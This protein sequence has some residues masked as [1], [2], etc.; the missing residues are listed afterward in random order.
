M[1]LTPYLYVPFVAWLVAQAIKVL[2]EVFKGE[3]DFRYLY[4]S[5]GM[6][7]AHS[8][9]VCALA[10]YTFYHEGIGSPLFGVTAVIAAIVMYDSFGVRRSAGEQARTLNKLI[11]D[12]SHSGS[13]RKPD[14]YNRL[15]EILGHQPLEVIVGALLGGLIATLFSL[16][17]ISP[18]IEWLTKPL[19]GAEI[20]LAYAVGGLILSAPI[21][22]RLALSKKIKADKNLRYIFKFILTGSITAGI[23][24]AFAGFVAQEAIN[25]YSQRWVSVSILTIW[26]AFMLVVFWRWMNM[27]RV[28]R[29][30]E[31]TG[32]I[33]RD[34]WL[35]KAGKKN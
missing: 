26:V 11:S 24:L 28:S 18:I 29:F 2:I 13:L 9:V 5:G 1:E 4:A 20:T 30:G 12:M 22:I 21:I 19:T 17:Q 35:K 6:P 3:A 23:V 34:H 32:S 27:R 8:A 7:S 25:L 31:D 15:R 10:G 16:N 33:R 14:D